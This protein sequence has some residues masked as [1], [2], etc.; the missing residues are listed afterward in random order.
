MYPS[1]GRPESKGRNVVA[2]K[3]KKHHP[4]SEFHFRAIDNLAAFLQPSYTKTS[5]HPFALLALL[6]LCL[7]ALSGCGGLNYKSLGTVTGT[8]QGNGVALSG[9]TCGTQ[10]LTGPQSKTCSVSLSSVALTSIT[11]TLSSSNSALTIPSSVKVAVGQSSANFDAVTP[12][13]NATATVTVSASYRG[14]TKSAALTLY[15][16]GTGGSQ[17]SAPHK[18][19]L[20]WSPPRTSGS[21]LTGYNVYRATVG[22]SSYA[23]LNPTIDTATS[24]LDTNVQSGL[25]YNYIVKSVDSQGSESGPSNSTQVTIP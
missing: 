10:S 19:Q 15:P 5:H 2:L 12:G 18:V 23:L 9:V 6:A 22:I 11:V 21:T 20:S 3:P 13:V 25:T 1:Q 14:V 4:L 8:S 16:A 7:A 17:T 24:Y